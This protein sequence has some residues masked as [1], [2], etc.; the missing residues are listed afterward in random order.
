MYDV[1]LIEKMING[2][3]I[4]EELHDDKEVKTQESL[5]PKRIN[6]DE[7]A[8]QTVRDIK[9][10][11][12]KG[13]AT[14]IALTGPYG[15]GKSSILITLKEDYPEHHYLNISLATLKPSDAIAKEK[16]GKGADENNEEEL[17]KLNLDRLIEYSILQQLIYKEKQEV[18]LNS[19]FKRIFHLTSK[20]V[21]EITLAIILAVLDIIIIFEPSFLR[22]EWLC[23]VFGREWMNVVGDSLSIIY[24]LW[25]AYEAI[26]M[27][28]PAVSNSRLNKLNLKDGEIEIVENTSIFNKHLDEILYF[29]EKTD[30]DV[31]MLEDLDRFES[32]D[33]FLKLRELNLLLNESKVIER[34]IFFVYAVRD[35]MFQDA[36]RVKCFDYITTVIPVI[37]RSN[38]KNQL[39]EELQRRG[40]TEISDH[41]LQELGFFLYDM[42]LLKNIA[43]EYVQY[44]GKLSAGI[45]SEKLLGMIVYKN[46]YPQDFA[47]LHDC[48]GMVYKLL[49]L[50]ETFVA[51]KIEELE[52]ENKR[53]RELQE[54]HQ[55][56]RHL[57]ETELRRIYLE[58]YREQLIST[59]QHIR[60]G[61]SNYSIK[62]IAAN[63]KLFEKLINNKSIKYTYIDTNGGYYGGQTRQ[64]SAD[65]SFENIEENIDSSKNYHER[66]DNL[67]TA[68]EELENSD[69]IDIRKDDIRSQTL[70]QIMGTIDYGS[71]EAYTKLNVPRMIEFL[72][73]KGYIDENYYDYI[74]YFYAN[75]IDAHDW[76]FVLDLKLNKAHPY[77]YH[78]NN[79]EACLD[80][81]P[82]SVYRKNAILNI[83]L[84]DY[85]AEHQADRMNKMR[86][87]V[88]L[89]TAIDG[90]K[91]DFI[92]AYYQKGC[93]QDVVFPLL[94]DQHKGQWSAWESKDDDKQSLKLSWFK[95]AEKEQSCEE[96]RK[97]LNE[98]FV[99]MADNLLDIDAEHW[100]TLI[101][102]G[103][104]QFEELNVVSR[105]ILNAVADTNAYKLTRHNV[106]VLVGY[107]LEMDLDS[108]SYTLVNQTEH[109]LLIERV[110]ENLGQC[111]KTVFAAP[112]SEKE[113]VDAILGILLDA[114]VMEVEKIAYLKKQQNKIDLEQ[115]EQKDIKTLAL[116]CDVVEVSWENV[117][118]Y[119]NEVSEKKA[120]TTLIAFVDKHSDELAMQGIDQLSSENVRNLL[121]QFIGTDDL[122]FESFTRIV[123]CFDRWYYEKGVPS[124][125]ERRAIVLNERG[126]LHYTVENTESF[127]SHYSPSALMAYLLKHKR[128][129]LK[130]PEAVEYSA[131][132]AVGLLRSSLTISE[133]ASIIPCFDVSILT[134]ELAD[135][136]MFILNKQEIM[137]NK[138]FLL[139]VMRLTNMPD[140][141]LRVMNYTLEKN[142]F[143]EDV[144]TDLIETLHL[145]YK[146]IA[147]KGKKPELPNNE[148]S[149]RL[150]K[151][152]KERDYIS[153]Y[154]ETKKG[155]RVNTKLK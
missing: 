38:A 80:E 123:G 139:K 115:A 153:S 64:A 145:P 89:R 105:D 135:E 120:D 125:E 22:V 21:C 110:E 85:L 50:K 9:E 148:E 109:E 137:L 42:R 69:F 149:W 129:W 136:I 56:E 151:V 18:L 114:Q 91:Y 63:E 77:D 97:W 33:I 26:S 39:K 154:S 83:D 132:A 141:R 72:V 108:V 36:E 86:M 127:I 101:G 133:K 111:I 5:Q 144:I 143:D 24:L 102:N 66:L 31:V 70:S 28:V 15:S 20:R 8:Y 6:P 93:R 119:L 116:K 81:I 124:I 107:L 32:I 113:S 37:N 45:S 14:N 106:E 140:E 74:S 112:E 82:K 128:E 95:Y 96:S 7:K 11:L 71:V 29:F 67:R 155:I 44:R 130:K 4:N 41:H 59:M 118:H 47:D 60:I 65:I 17:S 150:V 19:R 103:E 99:F 94:F 46:F 88:I 34:K 79:V 10:R 122:G 58:G 146:Y 54:S 84:V 30:Y 12:H 87:L 53:K 138:D 75:F 1:I 43:N 76:D 57:K 90:K 2:Q 117:V 152:L 92:A 62:D 49:N 134:E 55:K 98:H 78:I 16:N 27:I 73:V 121:A 51:A 40:V 126:M 100:C 104:Y 61:D 13:D 142:V 25:F 48:K 68:F 52:E 131:E 23:K 3:I 35:D 147:E